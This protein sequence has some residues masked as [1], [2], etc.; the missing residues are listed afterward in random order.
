MPQYVW[1]CLRTIYDNQWY[2]TQFYAD[3][4][5]HELFK[6]TDIL[7]QEKRRV[8]DKLR[9]ITISTLLQKNNLKFYKCS[10]DNVVGKIQFWYESRL[11]PQG[12]TPLFTVDQIQSNLIAQRLINS[13]IPIKR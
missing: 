7:K 3:I 11:S 9:G 10:N 6:N 1:V 5:T 2:E 12:Y 4:S 13:Y 8:F